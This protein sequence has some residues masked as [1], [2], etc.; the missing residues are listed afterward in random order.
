MLSNSAILVRFNVSQWTARK[1]DKKA[2]A[3][4]ELRHSTHGEV[5]RFNK[6][7]AAK[8]YLAE[9]TSNI[10]AARTFHYKNTLPWSDVEG[11]RILPV[12]NFNA[13]QEGMAEF[14]NKH[15]SALD[16]FVQNYPDVVNEAQ[17][18]LNGLFD[19]ADFPPVNQ[20]RSKFSWGISFDPV[21]DSGDFRVELGKDAIAK[22]ERDL[23]SR[24]ISNQHAAMLDL[25][26]RVYDQAMHISERL[27][28][29]TGT[30]EGCFRD[31]LIENAMSLSEL[32]PRLNVT[33]D[34]KLA[35]IA[36]RI[37]DELCQYAPDILREND[38]AR[39]DVADKA[40]KIADDAANIMNQMRGLFA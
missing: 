7:L 13:Y 21:P 15:E 39:V 11:V 35:E 33:G 28:N 17:Y 24:L 12:G 1:F 36:R 2:T 16:K 22:I 10:S 8:K 37:D 25:F 31:S 23:E 26:Q 38:A 32:L 6:Q 30:R 27:A 20:I 18:R 34:K 19:P 14:H 40:Q 3:E 9:L 4:V 5:G 29:Y